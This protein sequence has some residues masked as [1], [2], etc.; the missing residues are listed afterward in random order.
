MQRTH[1]ALSN[2]VSAMV[3]DGCSVGEWQ[4]EAGVVRKLEVFDPSHA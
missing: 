1:R 4:L 2:W 3:I